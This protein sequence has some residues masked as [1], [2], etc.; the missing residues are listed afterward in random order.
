MKL[1]GVSGCCP[2]YCTACPEVAL[3]PQGNTHLMT[4]CAAEFLQIRISGPIIYKYEC[5]SSI[6]VTNSDDGIICS[7]HKI[8]ITYI[9]SWQSCRD[10][11]QSL[12]PRKVVVQFYSEK[13]F[14]VP[15]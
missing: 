5:T 13:Q 10:R 4:V 15:S 3:W 1:F 11:A 12:L 9:C 7:C 14:V 8:C 6:S 2:C